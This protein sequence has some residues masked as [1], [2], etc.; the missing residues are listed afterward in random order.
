MANSKRPRRDGYTVGWICTLHEELTPAKAMLDMR[1]ERLPQPDQD[2]NSYILGEICGHNV[3]IACLPSGE[4]GTNAAASVATQMRSTFPEIQFLLM[5]GIGGGVPETAD[6][7]LGDVV[8]STPTGAYGG[9]VQYDLVKT[10]ADGHFIHTGMLNRPPQRLLTAVGNLRSERA[11]GFDRMSSFLRDMVNKYPEMA[12][13]QYPASASDNLYRTDYEHC[14]GEN[15]CDE[16]CDQGMLVARS[17]RPSKK[18][19]IYYGLIAS[20]NQV[21]KHAASRARIAQQ[22]NIM[23]FEMEAAGLMNQF[24]CLV[25]RG[26]CDYSDSHKNKQWQCYAA[27]TAAAFAK[28][29]LGMVYVSQ[30]VDTT[31]IGDL[32]VPVGC[33]KTLT[34][35]TVVHFL[36]TIRP[37]SDVF[38]AHYFYSYSD[39]TGLSAKS[40]LESFSKQILGY[41]TCIDRPYPKDMLKRIKALYT[42]S[43]LPATLGEVVED[44]FLPCCRAVPDAIYIIDGLD[45]CEKS[46]IVHVFGVIRKMIY[47][48]NSRVLISARDGI[49][50]VQAVPLAVTISIADQG[51]DNDICRFINWK[52]GEK[53]QDRPLTEDAAL[54]QDVKA[55]LLRKADYMFLWVELQLEMLWEDCYTDADIR[56][57]LENL[58]KTLSETY[59]RCISR[60]NRKQGGV[61]RRVLYWVC[62]AIKPFDAFQLQE[63]LAMDPE[64]G[65]VDAQRMLPRREIVKLCCHLVIWDTNDNIRLA[66]A[67]VYQFLQERSA[68][69]EQLWSEYTIAEARLEL[70][71]LCLTQLLPLCTGGMLERYAGPDGLANSASVLQIIKKHIPYSEFLRFSRPRSAQ[72]PWPPRPAQGRAITEELAF[73]QF[74]KYH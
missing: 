44:I 32:E 45:E 13:F 28:E 53:S 1:R 4:Y 33:G 64:T 58:P 57:A 41:L 30:P 49:D 74:A 59:D 12:N 38:V 51:D 66:H 36:E 16:T 43:S 14:G 8:V 50:V 39:R 23:C 65:T 71:E 47:E 48:N 55:K 40:L 18:P 72:I 17:Q 2:N 67:S 9:V 3:V 31:S 73:S 42:S 68:D 7:R 21:I 52:I 56:I 34:T 15:P 10:V 20:G 29:L 46:E 5:V 60:I 22:Y 19:Q 35:S 70:A 11:M 69:I 6:I 37:D 25:I 26:I 54:L 62:V 24:P 61:A 63:A 27:A